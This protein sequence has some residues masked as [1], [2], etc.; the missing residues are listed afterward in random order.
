MN[1][2]TVKPEKVE[3]VTRTILGTTDPG[4]QTLGSDHHRYAIA[5][6]D[7]LGTDPMADDG[8]NKWTPSRK[9]GTRRGT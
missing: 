8:I 2:S 4:R 1:W 9:V 7:K 6:P 5:R 3:P